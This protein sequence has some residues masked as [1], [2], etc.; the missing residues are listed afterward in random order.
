M[1]VVLAAE[2]SAGSQILRTLAGSKHHLVA[3]LAAP[4][5]AGVAAASVWNVARDLGCETW[6]AE[7]VKNPSLGER[8][9]SRQV[10]I[11]LNVHSLYVID[12]DVLAAP[13]LGC[14]NLHPGPLPRYAGLNSVSWALFR[15]EQTHGVTVHRMDL[16]I[17]S[18]PIAYQSCFPIEPE[19]TALSLSL[20]CAREGVALMLHLLQ[21]ADSG[22]TSIPSLPQDPTMREY[23]GKEV[24]EQGWVSWSWP[25]CKVLNFVRA[26]DY[27]PF[28]SPWG[29]PRTSM[30]VQEF[31]L[32]KASRTGLSCDAPPGTVGD[33]TD[34]G[35]Y[36]ACR[37][38]WILASKL[39]VNGRYLPAREVLR[40]GE[41]LAYS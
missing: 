41:C 28:P 14:F 11:L 27:F 21:A 16:A 6:P 30:G 32:V 31:A 23:F 26:C 2:E 10:D 36:V 25:A 37:D 18:G 15:G 33:A 39:L 1:N 3:V 29:H 38:E 9:R 12:K 24:P 7:L 13:R 5:K 34:S 19:D 20:K 4:P 35:V 17:D 8:L 40:S 22:G